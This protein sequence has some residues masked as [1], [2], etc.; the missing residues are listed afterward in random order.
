MTGKT[1][2]LQACRDSG[3]IPVSFFVRNMQHA[4][5]DIKHHGLGPMGAKAI[6]VALVVCIDSS[7]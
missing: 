6:A 2:Y 5:I 7:N 4:E 3:V 1:T